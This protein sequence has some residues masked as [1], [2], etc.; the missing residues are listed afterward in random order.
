L[1]EHNWQ[2]NEKDLYKVIDGQMYCIT[3]MQILVCLE[4]SK[5]TEK[6]MESLEKYLLQV[7]N[8]V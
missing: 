3:A 2:E 7:S 5:N 6:T 4:A 1:K 8:D